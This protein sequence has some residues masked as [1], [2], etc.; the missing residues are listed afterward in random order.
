MSVTNQPN[1]ATVLLLSLSDLPFCWAFWG[2]LTRVCECGSAVFEFLSNVSFSKMAAIRCGKTPA[3]WIF[4]L[5]RKFFP[6]NDSGFAWEFPGETSFEASIAFE[7]LQP[8]W[9]ER[10]FPIQIWFEL[11]FHYT[12]ARWLSLGLTRSAPNVL[13]VANAFTK[14]RRA[15][16][17]N[18]FRSTILLFS[19]KKVIE[20]M[21]QGEETINLP[22]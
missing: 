10:K 1:P 8:R 19:T 6:R 14:Y 4:W 21:V 17:L 13:S 15:V 20:K 12:S 16:D 7:M 3:R 22:W 2:G 18:T 11:K 5:P 9:F